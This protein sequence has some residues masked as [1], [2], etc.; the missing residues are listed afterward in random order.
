MVKWSWLLHNQGG[1]QSP[2]TWALKELLWLPYIPFPSVSVHSWAFKLDC[3][4]CPFFL[5]NSFC[6]F[7]CHP[8]CCP[9]LLPFL[10]PSIN[11]PGFQ[12]LSARHFCLQASPLLPVE[13]GFSTIVSSISHPCL[14]ALYDS[15]IKAA[16]NIGQTLTLQTKPKKLV[17]DDFLPV[18]GVCFV[19]V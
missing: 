6:L 1:T 8:S 2:I 14:P 10:P 19:T 18:L 7:M 15:V 3:V 4:F 5:K 12:K 9:R 17:Y 11:S 13:G 16:A